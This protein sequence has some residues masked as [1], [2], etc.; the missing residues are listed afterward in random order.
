MKYHNTLRRL[1]AGLLVMTAV[2][3]LYAPA[4]HSADTSGQPE[5]RCRTFELV[6]ELADW[7]GAAFSADN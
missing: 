1:E 5:L 2:L 4:N 7:F 6:Q 3:F